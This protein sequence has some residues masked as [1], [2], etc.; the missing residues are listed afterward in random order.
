MRT[1]KL[2]GRT[3]EGMTTLEIVDGE[4]KEEKHINGVRC[5]LS[6]PNPVNPG[7]YFC[8]IGQEDKR[9]PTGERGLIFISEFEAQSIAAL[10]QEMFDQLGTY[11][12]FEIYAEILA[13]EWS[14][15][16]IE[17]IQS[18][19]V[20]FDDYQTSRKAQRVELLQAPFCKS[21]IHGVDI[22]KRWTTYI[23]ALGIPRE[24]IIRKQLSQINDEA[25]KKSP[26]NVF[27]A[28]NALRYVLGA[29]EVSP[30]IPK[31]GVETGSV[32]VPS[33]AWT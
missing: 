8:L 2:K 24:T 20:A 27:F 3:I 23:S 31:V 4:K 1:V 22:I 14:E 9:V 11:G 13:S 7:G 25:L 21:F 17:G 32:P 29:F 33:G 6:W 16:P 5:G 30:I 10:L 19:L 18:Y 15:R 26:E 12:C 28:I